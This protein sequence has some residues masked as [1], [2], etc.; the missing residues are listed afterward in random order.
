MACGQWRLAAAAGSHEDSASEAGAGGTYVPIP[1]SA[2]LPRA[3]NTTY[4]TAPT[5]N[6]KKRRAATNPHRRARLAWCRAYARRAGGEEAAPLI[7]V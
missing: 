7:L 2:L 4:T 1:V 6:T 3:V 5:P